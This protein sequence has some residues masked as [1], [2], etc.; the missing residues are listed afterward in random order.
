RT[1][2]TKAKSGTQQSIIPGKLLIRV[3]IN[4]LKLAPCSPNFSFARCSN[5]F[6]IGVCGFPDWKNAGSLFLVKDWSVLALASGGGPGG[7]GTAGV[8]EAGAGAGL[9]RFSACS[10]L[11][12]A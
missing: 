2:S 7:L 5:H 10:I 4:A 1:F 12:R 8:A 6:S 3:M 9:S 11:W